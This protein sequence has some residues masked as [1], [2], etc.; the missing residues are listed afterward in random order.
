MTMEDKIQQHEWE[1]YKAV[2]KCKYCGVR[3]TITIDRMYGNRIIY[4]TGDTTD[5]DVFN[6]EP[7]CITRQI[8]DPSGSYAMGPG[9]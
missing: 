8:N 9:H 2:K 4:W 3:T 5:D 7:A 6:E 1:P